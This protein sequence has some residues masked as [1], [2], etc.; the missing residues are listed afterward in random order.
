MNVPKAAT[1]L[2]EVAAGVLFSTG[3]GRRLLMGVDWMPNNILVTDELAKI[4]DYLEQC[5]AIDVESYLG[6]NLPA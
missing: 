1:A 2:C 5:E 6:R 3:D 4:N